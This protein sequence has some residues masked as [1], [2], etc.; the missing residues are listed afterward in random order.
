MYREGEWER[1][2]PDE[3]VPVVCED[4]EHLAREPALYAQYCQYHTQNTM[5]KEGAYGDVEEVTPRLDEQEVKQDN[6]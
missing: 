3:L 5:M 4:V 2:V 6:R 1:C